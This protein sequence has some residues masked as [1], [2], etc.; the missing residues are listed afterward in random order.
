M[1]AKPEN[2]LQTRVTLNEP[3]F[4][5]RIRKPL[6]EVTPIPLDERKIIGRRAA[7]ELRTGAI[8]NMGIGMPDTVSN[9]AADENV[10]DL[11][12]LTIELGALAVSRHKAW[13]SRQRLTLTALL[14][15]RACLT[16]MM[17]VGW[18]YAS[19]GQP[20]LMKREIPTSASLDRK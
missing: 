19:W 4:D 14:I 9:T 1:V 12:S 13:T 16:F 10:A 18:I 3:A 8:V 17:A 20:K 6:S 11:M 15:T 2:H 5:G 7:M